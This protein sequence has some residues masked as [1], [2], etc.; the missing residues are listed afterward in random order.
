MGLVNPAVTAR[1]L[2][3][4]LAS[5]HEQPEVYRQRGWVLLAQRGVEIEVGFLARVPLGPQ[6]LH[7]MTACVRFDFTDYDLRPPSVEF[8]D[9][10][11]GDYQA[12]I[13]PAIVPTDEGPRNVLISSHPDTNRPFFCVP[14]TRQ[15]HDHPQHSGDS[16]LLH[17]D[18]GEGTLAT[19]CDRVWRA[20][21]RSVIGLRVGMMTLPLE[22]G[23]PLQAEFQVIT[24]DVDALRSAIDGAG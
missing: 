10:V 14:G 7:A 5:W 9:P 23:Q 21:A 1:K 11:T 4:E 15:Y 20:M 16:W 18:T 22:T 8:I 2:E 12:P 24:G 13:V 3:R 19:L 6:V 17:R